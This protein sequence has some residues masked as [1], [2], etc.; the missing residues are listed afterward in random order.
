MKMGFK[1]LNG[2]SRKRKKEVISG[3]HE[4]SREKC[5]QKPLQAKI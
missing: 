3:Y 2:G 4:K 1:M 5:I